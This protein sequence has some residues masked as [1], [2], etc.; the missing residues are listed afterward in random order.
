MKRNCPKILLLSG[1]PG[2]GKTTIVNKLEEKFGWR[3]LRLG[4]FIINHK[5]YITEDKKRDTK[6]INTELV[7][8][9]GFIE[10]LRRGFKDLPPINQKSVNVSQKSIIVVDSHYADIIF[11]GIRNFKLDFGKII[12]EFPIPVLNDM[13]KLCIEDYKKEKNIIGMILRCNPQILEKRLVNRRYSNNKVMENIQA[14]ILG[15][16]SNN[17]LKVLKRDILFEIDTTNLTEDEVTNKV[18][19]IIGDPNA[20][21]DK[22]GLGKIN[23]IKM[24]TIEGTLNK[25]FKKN[26]GFKQEIKYSKVDQSLIF[27]DMEKD[28]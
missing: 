25:Y 2:T 27:K 5:L 28:E 26:L 21:I 3:V 19:K 12:E 15:E 18:F 10:V 16:C 7:A 22:N 17:M 14:E 8:E 23:W 1:T 9:K 13:I 20:Y 24:L 6:V 4:D 11:D